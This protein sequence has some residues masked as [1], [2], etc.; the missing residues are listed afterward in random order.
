[1][2]LSSI[3][4]EARDANDPTR[5]RNNCHFTAPSCSHPGRDLQGA[6]YSA[7]VEINAPSQLVF[8]WMTE[9]EKLTQWIRGLVGSEP[10]G[11]PG[12]KV[13]ARS[14]ETIEEG[15][16]TCV[17]ESEVLELVPNEKLV[18]A[19]EMKRGPTMKSI[20]S[21]TLLEEAGRTTVR[22]DQEGSYGGFFMKVLAR[23]MQEIRIRVDW[24]PEKM[25]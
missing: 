1:M 11:D 21:Y 12:L 19:L 5:S 22:L 16:R 25:P 14:L 18:V 8:S 17:M 9:P 20:A 7:E 2:Q 15:G 24:G 23:I 10:I 4:M 6:R 3:H 13:G